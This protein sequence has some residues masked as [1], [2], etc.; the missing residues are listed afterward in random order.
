MVFE[1]PFSLLLRLVR[2]PVVFGS[3]VILFGIFACCIG[4]SHAYWAVLILRLFIG[5]AEAVVQTGNMYL[6]L[7][8]QRDEIATRAGECL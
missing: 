7:W 2:P 8:Y 6:S 3:G 1:L 4:S 5:I